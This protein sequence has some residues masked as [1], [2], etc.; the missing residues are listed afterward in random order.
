MAVSQKFGLWRQLE[1]LSESLEIAPKKDADLS[2]K[3]AGDL[4]LPQS[5]TSTVLSE[6]GSKILHAL[7][8]EFPSQEGKGENLVR[9]LESLRRL[10]ILLS[11]RSS[12]AL[13]LT[14]CLHSLLVNVSHFVEQQSQQD[15]IKPLLLKD[16]CNDQIK[17]F[18]QQLTASIASFQVSFAYSLHHAG[19]NE[20][21]NQISTLHDIQSWQKSNDMD[22]KE[23]LRLLYERFAQLELNQSRLTNALGELY[24]PLPSRTVI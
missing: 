5:P 4:S 24:F 22:R 10:V 3:V 18:H 20:L 6:C 11:S 17:L 19:F 13:V 14:E 8:M 7:D 15:F 23:S 21:F 2:L 1:T 16:D 9:Q 12:R